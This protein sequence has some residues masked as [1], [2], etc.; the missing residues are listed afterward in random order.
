MAAIAERITNRALITSSAG[1]ALVS[2]EYA[3][4]AHHNTASSAL[5]RTGP[6]EVIGEK[7]GYLGEGEDEDQVEE[8]FQRR[9][10]L[11]GEIP[12]LSRRT[13][14]ARRAHPMPSYPLPAFTSMSVFWH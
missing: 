9:N 2:H 14:R 6:R 4:H 1:T 5:Q 13:C 3:P 7:A 10:A 12:A 8:Q 11:L